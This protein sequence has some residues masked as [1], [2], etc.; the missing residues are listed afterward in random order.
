MEVIT[1]KFLVGLDTERQDKID[2]ITQEKE[3]KYKRQSGRRHNLY[4]SIFQ[5]LPLTL[6]VVPV[7][8]LYCRK[9]LA[10]NRMLLLHPVTTVT[11]YCGTLHIFVVNILALLFSTY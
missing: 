9:P 6:I 11:C 3:K 4:F 8:E 1:R 2:K 7:V 10:R 5:V